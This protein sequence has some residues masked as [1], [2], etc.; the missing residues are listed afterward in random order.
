ML[1]R[2]KQNNLDNIYIE[3]LKTKSERQLKVM[4]DTLEKETIKIQAEKAKLENKLKDK[5]KKG[6]FIKDALME[7]WRTPSPELLEAIEEIK[8][9]GGTLCKSME[10]FNRQ[11]AE[12]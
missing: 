12:D 5:I 2:E 11:M 1:A 6:H 9:G 4:L 7:K 3:K 10:E 8:N